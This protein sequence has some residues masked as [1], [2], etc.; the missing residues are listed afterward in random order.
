MPKKRIT[1]VL[2]DSKIMECVV[3]K[4]SKQAVKFI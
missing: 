1:L 4:K 2:F 3:N